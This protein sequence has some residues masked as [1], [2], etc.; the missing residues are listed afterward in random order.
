[1]A[2]LQYVEVPEYSGILFRRTY[3]DLSL[4]GALMDRAQDW[5]AGTVARWSDKEKTWHFP[6]G[7][8]ISFG[9]L[10]TENDKYRYQSAEFQF[11]GF[12]ELTQFAETQYRYL[13]SR[14]RRLV[15][16]RIPIR[17]RGASN[18]GGVGHDWVKRRFLIEGPVKDRPFI[19]A[20]VEDN[21]HVDSKA[22]LQTLENLDPLTRQ[23][24]REGNWFARPPG[25]KF[26][27]EWFEIIGTAPAEVRKVRYWDLAA[28]EPRPGRDP[29][30]TAGVLLGEYD[31][32]FYLIDIRRVQGS[33]ATIESIIKQ[34]AYID[35]IQTSIYMEQEPGSSGIN[36]IDHYARTI[37]L[38]FNFHGNKTTGSKEIRSNPASSAAE[39][40][41]IK[42]VSGRWI[43]DFL[44]EIGVFPDP[45]YHDD[46]VD[47][48]SGAFA[49]LTN[50]AQAWELPYA[51]DDRWGPI[52]IPG[53]RED[54]SRFAMSPEMQEHI[55]E[56]RNKNPW[57]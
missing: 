36:T 35:G 10:E 46:Q 38:G 34:T 12:D 30:W 24:L 1:M 49:M 9:Y 48:L 14:L 5:L 15:D 50:Q 6:S 45:A 53:S 57:D 20:R 11:V 18:P 8:T 13:F 21:P 23:Y 43:N 17:M 33:P 7:A 2:A 52:V 26:K 47:A 51:P 55:A 4:P 31:G 3:T 41:N 44:D 54:L 56:R 28:T 29:D 32:I 37:L 40:K 19:P 39:A 22:Y 16:S 42:L 25:K 27:R